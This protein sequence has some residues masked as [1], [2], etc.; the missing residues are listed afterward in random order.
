MTLPSAGISVVVNKRTYGVLSRMKSLSTED[1][2][3]YFDE[4]K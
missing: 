2:K 1:L 4:L 3:T